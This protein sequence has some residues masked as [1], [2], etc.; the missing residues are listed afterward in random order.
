MELTR[1]N[2]VFLISLASLIPRLSANIAEY[3]EVWRRR[4]E[5]ARKATVESYH[6]DPLS[7]LNDLNMH[8]QK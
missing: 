4:A 7:V 2:L 5:E 3:D 8:F 6:P 1:L